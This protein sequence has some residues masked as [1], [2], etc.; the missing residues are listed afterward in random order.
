[1]DN[2]FEITFFSDSKYEEITA[3]ISYKDQILCQ[4]NK[5]KGPDNI[6]IEFFSDARVLAEQ[7][8][9][10][11]SLSSFLQIIAEATEEL[12]IS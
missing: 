9:M 5:D 8:K 7:D 4:L 2:D 10:K 1:M 6:E 3:E 11:F 12:K